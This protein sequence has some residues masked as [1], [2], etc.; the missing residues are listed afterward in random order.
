MATATKFEKQ[1]F[2]ENGLV[3]IGGSG[4]SLTTPEG[5]YCAVTFIQDSVIA[6]T[7]ILSCFDATAGALYTDVFP[8]G[9]TIY[10]KFDRV[11]LTSGSAIVYASS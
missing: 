7:T 8:A 1:Q 9:V 6:N 10:G 2:G 4:S 11:T 3:Y 5:K